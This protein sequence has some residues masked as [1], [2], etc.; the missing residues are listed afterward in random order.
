MDLYEWLGG[1]ESI[2][3]SIKKSI[4]IENPEVSEELEPLK[5]EVEKK[6]ENSGGN[7]NKEPKPQNYKRQS[8]KKKGREKA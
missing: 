7:K 3:T 8:T 5:I 1:D 4:K 6:K 2:L